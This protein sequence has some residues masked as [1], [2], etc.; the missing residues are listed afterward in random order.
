VVEAAGTASSTTISAGNETVK[1]GGKDLGARISGGAQDV[2]GLAS[3]AAI[4]TGGSQVVETGGSARQLGAS[5]CSEQMR[6]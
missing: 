5:I 6:T 4:F 1:A 2:F 3:G